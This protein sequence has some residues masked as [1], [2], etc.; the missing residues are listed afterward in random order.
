[1]K[2][3]TRIKL[4]FIRNWNLPGTER[5]AGWLSKSAGIKAIKNSITWLTNEDISVF[6][7]ADSYIEYTILSTG[8]YEDEIGKLIRTSLKPGF[9]AV[10]IGA[11]IGLQSI[12]MSQACGAEGKVFAFEPLVYLQQKYKRNIALNRCDN[13]TLLPY[14]LSDTADEREISVNAAEWNQGTFS[15]SQQ[16]QGNSR[17]QLIIKVGD[18]LPE[19]ANAPRIDLIKIDVEGFEFQVMRGLQ[20]T[21]SKHKPRII[22]EYDDSYWQQTGQQMSE[23]YAFLKVLNYTLYQITQVGCEP[24]ESLEQITGGNIFCLPAHEFAEL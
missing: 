18:E 17:Q 10:D 6:T 23:C 20:Q 22:F 4:N 13:V 5:M 9:I 8:T 16:Q 24:I 21:L 19:L 11:N 2:R 1:M 15:L 14:A 3:N 12:R 7:S